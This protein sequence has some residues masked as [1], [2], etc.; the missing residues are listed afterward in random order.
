MEN[1]KKVKVMVE[2]GK[3][4]A[5]PPIGSTLGP[6]GVDVAQIVS[7][8]NEKTKNLTGMQIPVSIE[9][10]VKTKEFTCTLGKPPVSAL[11][12][13]ELNLDKGSKEPGK[14][15]AGDLTEGQVK[16]IASMKF[17]SEEPSL[18]SQVTGTARSMGIT[19][20]Q[21]AVSEEELKAYEDTKAAE[22]AAKT[23]PAEGEA[24][25]E[26]EGKEVKLDEKGPEKSEGKPA[27]KAAGEKPKEEKSKKSGTKGK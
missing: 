22:E 6:L 7:D 27:G 16:S 11:I 13:E 17:D 24:P 15:R 10:N 20:G 18:L 5:G 26:G 21:G 14:L 4:S 8:I 3:A 25:A 12:K 19:V 2:G 9:V 23:K 1:I